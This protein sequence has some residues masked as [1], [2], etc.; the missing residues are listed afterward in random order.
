MTPE[1]KTLLE[2]V[3]Q[4]IESTEET[5]DGEWGAGRSV[6]EI[7]AAREMPGLYAR[8]LAALANVEMRDAPGA[9]SRKHSDS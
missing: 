4:Y 8:V 2:D 3:K 7:I 6:E 5:I 9:P 1:L